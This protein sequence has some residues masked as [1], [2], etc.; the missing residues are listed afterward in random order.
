[1]VV[2]SLPPFETLYFGARESS[3]IKPVNHV[4]DLAAAVKLCSVVIHH[5][6][7]TTPPYPTA[8]QVM[9]VKLLQHTY[10]GQV[11]HLSTTLIH[12]LMQPASGVNFTCSRVMII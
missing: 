2:C 6:K 3:D 8:K 5:R 7:V 10:V 4:D 11:S 9:L 12:I 1:M